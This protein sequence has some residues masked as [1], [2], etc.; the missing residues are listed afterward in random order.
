MVLYVAA[1]L[2]SFSSRTEV[3][4]KHD[5]ASGPVAFDT[6]FP[7]GEFHSPLAIKQLQQAKADRDEAS[8]S[9]QHND[10][11]HAVELYEAARQVY[12]T[13]GINEKSVTWGPPAVIEYAQ[14]LSELSN[15]L[16]KIG[17]LNDAVRGWSDADN[18]FSL[19]GILNAFTFLI[20]ERHPELTQNPALIAARQLTSANLLLFGLPGI[21]GYATS[22]DSAEQ[23][24]RDHR[25]TG[26]SAK[27]SG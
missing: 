23:F 18:Y 19:A 6:F 20:L 17:R 9:L 21:N 25:P 16:I 1:I 10:I 27:I 5:Q 4:H 2:L 14:C 8:L 3:A 24:H 7:R 15:A 11:A 13:L 26:G 12:E 22:K